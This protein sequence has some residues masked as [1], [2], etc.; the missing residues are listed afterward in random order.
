MVWLGIAI[1]IAVLVTIV[2]PIGV[3]FWLNKKYQIPWRIV[4]YGVM[5]YL[6]MQSVVSLI[7]AGIGTLV[8]NGTFTLS[9]TGLTTI[10]VVLNILLAAILGVVIRWAIVKLFP[11]KLDT[12]EA[13]FGIGVGYGGAE[14]VMLVGLP[15]LITFVT[16]LSHLDYQSAAAGLEPDM[17]SQLEALWA[18]SPLVPLAGS[19]ERLAALVMHLTV[20]ML[21]FQYF[22]LRKKSYLFA[23]AGVELVVNGL[24]VGLSEAGLAYGWVI[25]ISVILMG[26]NLYLLWK[27]KAFSLKEYVPEPKL[28]ETK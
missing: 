20:T 6:V 24:V 15:L 16:M 19:V 27:M 25:L 4:M 12:R 23:A 17:V 1:T 9:E 18:V 3:G 14:S 21:V 22:L 26:G 5:G 7:L 8:T 13:S 28:P 10:Q 2:F 11:E